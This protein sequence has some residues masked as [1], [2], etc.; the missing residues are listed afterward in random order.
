MQDVKTHRRKQKTKYGIR[1]VLV[2][3]FQRKGK[4]REKKKNNTLRNVAIGGIASVGLAAAGVVAAQR[5]MTPQRKAQLF[6]SVLT[7]LDKGRLNKLSQKVYNSKLVPPKYKASFK[8]MQG[9]AKAFFGIEL[10]KTKGF[11]VVNVDS[12][13]NVS[14][15]LNKEA[16]EIIS[17][18]SFGNNV[19][20]FKSK[21]RYTIPFD[22]GDFDL[23][24]MSFQVNNEVSRMKKL[25]KKESFQAIRQIKQAFKDQSKVIPNNSY[26]M[27]DAWEADGL[28]KKRKGIYKRMGFKKVGSKHGTFMI[29]KDGKLQK[30]DGQ[31][32]N[33]IASVGFVHNNKLTNF[34]MISNFRFTA[35]KQLGG[36]VKKALGTDVGQLLKRNK[37]GLIGT[38]KQK[39]APTTPA[40]LIKKKVNE[41]GR[42][43]KQYR[44]PEQIKRDLGML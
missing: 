20:T 17:V 25:D 14:T 33:R 19:M 40:N 4:E 2:R 30:I 43:G 31:D 1:E 16:E 28:G 26:V 22:D 6:E 35:L 5:L 29:K 3:K 38:A 39:I 7:S 32:T 10:L 15:L 8:E 11:N 18:G 21:Q 9:T 27:A 44:S 34:T 24:E 37:K 12:K 42:K 41:A 36:K 13:L 23:Y